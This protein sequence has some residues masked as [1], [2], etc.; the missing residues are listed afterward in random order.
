MCGRYALVDGKRVFLSWEN[1]KQ[2]ERDGVVFEIL[3][4]YNA[5]PTQKMPVVAVRENATKIGMMQWGL[6]PHWSK[7]PKT[8]FS[9]I[10]AVGEKLGET[11][12]MPPIF[13]QADA[14]SRP[15]R[16]TNGRNS[17]SRKKCAAER[18]R[19]RKNSRCASV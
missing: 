10:N 12:S 11:S 14:W 19:S 4:R 17:R 8:A 15:T 3:P 5:A 18:Q 9:T 16:F 2:M 7:E 13:G 1:M 6:V